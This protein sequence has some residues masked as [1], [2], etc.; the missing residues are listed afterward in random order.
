MLACKCCQTLLAWEYKNYICLISSVTAFS[1]FTLHMQSEQGVHGLNRYETFQSKA[2]DW[3][4]FN[5]TYHAI[6]CT[7]IA[8]CIGFVVKKM[9]FLAHMYNEIRKS[10]AKRS[11]RPTS[12]TTNVL[13]KSHSNNG[14]PLHVVQDTSVSKKEFKETFIHFS[15]HCFALSKID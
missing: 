12:N 14:Y 3:L 5:K 11:H 15:Q 9:S 4:L 7:A 8:F 10:F 13:C 1:G 6:F 2:F